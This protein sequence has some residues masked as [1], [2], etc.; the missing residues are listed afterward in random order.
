MVG[1][2]SRVADVATQVAEW[3]GTD[4]RLSGVEL[5]RRARAVGYRGGKSALYD[6]VRRIRGAEAVARHRSDITP[7]LHAALEFAAADI[8]YETGQ[9]ERV[10]FLIGEL[11]WSTFMHVTLAP[12]RRYSVSG[13]RAAARRRRGAG[14][15]VHCVLDLLATFGGAPLAMVWCSP[16]LVARVRDGGAIDWDPALARL[17]LQ[18]GF[19]LQLTDLRRGGLASRP[20]RGARWM[21]STF[22]A[23]HTFRDR[24]DL[25]AR[26]TDWLAENNRRRIRAAPAVELLPAER[27]LLRPLPRC[28]RDR[29][30]FTEN[31][32][33]EF[34][35][36]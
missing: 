27:A 9:R 21:K 34:S 10:V 8:G 26:L 7:G 12:R 19:A 5:L 36:S 11:L 6:L 31:S 1:R 13:G 30:E 4:P 20:R 35:E 29:R 14:P 25:E 23:A 28:D 33:Y 24:A 18:S 15:T 22:F 17:A 32:E 2:P 3:L 16:R